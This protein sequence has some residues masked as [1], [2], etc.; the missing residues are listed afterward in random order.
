MQK[1]AIR[2]VLVWDGEPDPAI[3]HAASKE[4][5]PGSEEVARAPEGARR[6][7][8]TSPVQRKENKGLDRAAIEEEAKRRRQERRRAEQAARDAVAQAAESNAAQHRANPSAGGI[9]PRGAQPQAQTVAQPTGAATTDVAPQGKALRRESVLSEGERPQVGRSQAAGGRKGASAPGTRTYEIRPGDTLSEIAM[10]EHGTTVIFSTHDMD[11]AERMCDTIFMIFQGRKVLDGT[12]ES[13][14][15]QY[16]KD[17]VRLRLEGGAG[18]LHGMSAVDRVMDMGRYQEVRINGDA[19]DFLT[20][21]VQK[22]RIQLFEETR[23][24]LHDIFIRIASP[25]EGELTN[26]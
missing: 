1:R 23:P 9:V 3:A 17:T 13:I 8:M 20:E 26:V 24:S 4:V 7:T 10:R 19:H 5:R 2:K 6:V 18:A 22:T 15:E 11:V 14:Q 12:L 16:G 21:L 25:E